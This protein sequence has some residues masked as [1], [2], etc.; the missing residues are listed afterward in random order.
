MTEQAVAV[1]E[2]KPVEVRQFTASEI[3]LIKRTMAVGATDDEL[4]LFLY[5]ARHVG[6]DPLRRQIHFVKRKRYDPETQKYIDVGTIQTGIDGYRLISDRTGKLR[7]IKRGVIRDDKGQLIGAW[8]EVYRS[9]WDFPAR[10]EVSFV[11]YCQT[12][13]NGNPMAMWKTIPE[14]MIQKVAEVAAHRMAFP[15]RFANLYSDDEMMQADKPEGATSQNRPPVEK[16]DKPAFDTKSEYYCKEHK[17]VWFKKG[18]MQHF[19]HPIKDDKGNAVVDGASGKPIWCNMPEKHEAP[20]TATKPA[21][22]QQAPPAQPQ[23]QTNTVPVRD[24]VTPEE[25]ED[26]FNE[27]AEA[28]ISPDRVDQLSRALTAAG[29]FPKDREK[30]F[31]DWKIEKLSDL[32]VHQGELVEAWCKRKQAENEAKQAQAK[33]QKLV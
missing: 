25:G 26:I 1:V 5:T 31:Q 17:T 33:P 3:D 19:A 20:K 15:D 12:D 18:N 14:T 27:T 9:D 22:A 24:L 8:A 16:G 28:K 6:L 30:L 13:K 32:T 10:T 11:E 23:G 29:Y 4:A 21:P 2:A 7:G